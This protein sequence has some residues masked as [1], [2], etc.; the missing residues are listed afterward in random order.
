MSVINTNM[1]AV[2]GARHLNQSQEALG[3]SLNR[4]SSGSKLVKPSEDPAGVGVSRKMDAL[5]LRV[6]AAATNIQ[7]SLSFVQT[8]DSIMQNMTQV[9]S[10]LGELAALSRD[11]TKNPADTA[12]YQQEFKALQDQL[13]DTIGGSTAEI[14]G[15]TAVSS[16][17]GTFNGNP[18]FGPVANG[19]TTV[20]AGGSAGE[21]IKIPETNLRSG[22]ILNLIAQDAGGDYLI[23]AASANVV[24]VV[25]SANEQL[26]ANRATLGAAASRLSYAGTMLRVEGE[27]LS[28]ALSGIQDVDVAQESTRLA[29]YNIL[30][31]SGTAML[32]QANQSPQSVLKLLQN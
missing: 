21:Q 20:G 11:L 28:A 29:K 27:N 19:G 22:A 24:N 5:S 4:L 12:L 31:Q 14:G 16:P 8:A 23:H 32:A 6:S 3:R 18:L 26:A 15:T 1:Q 13:R 25:T 17:L 2:I 30:V 10:R 7:N 9:L